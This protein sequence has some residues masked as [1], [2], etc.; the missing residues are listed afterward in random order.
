MILQWPRT[1]DCLNCLEIKDEASRQSAH[2]EIAK[3]TVGSS[4]KVCIE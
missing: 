1:N 4:Q 2:I 3:R